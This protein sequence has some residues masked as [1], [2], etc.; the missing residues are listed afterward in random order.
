MLHYAVDVG[1]RRVIL[2]GAGGR[3]KGIIEEL[4]EDVEIVAILDND[5][6]KWNNLLAGIKV[7]NPLD[8]YKMYYDIIFIVP[9]EYYHIHK[10]LIDMGVENEKVFNYTHVELICKETP[11]CCY[12]MSAFSE[13]KNV[14][15]FTHALSSTGAQNV[16]M[17]T[18]YEYQKMGYSVIVIST[19]DG[20]L[21]EE[22][23]NRGVQV[24]IIRDL[25]IHKNLVNELLCRADLVIINTLWL[26][27]V[28]LEICT[29][30]HNV[31]W[32]IH[33]SLNIEFFN[34]TVFS[35]CI[36]R[37]I[38][39]YAVSELVRNDILKAC[40]GRLTCNSIGILRFGIPEYKIE[41]KSHEKMN[42]I[43]LAAMA[44]IKGQDIFI[45]AVKQLPEDIK[46]KAGFFLIGGGRRSDNL[47]EA[48][49]EA[50]VYILDEVPHSEIKAIYEKA[51]V[52]VCPSRKEAM[53][54]TIVEAMMHHKPVIVSD[55]AGIASY[56]ENNKNG[57][58]FES[59]NIKELRDAIL[60]MISNEDTMKL[61]G[62]EEY[63]IYERFFNLNIHRKNIQKLLELPKNKI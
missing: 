23:V 16:L 13:K 52:I 14:I 42:F 49:K 12:G 6:K 57:I 27:Y 21:R 33:E 9:Y 55:A 1:M 59:E 24:K 25:Y 43:V 51:D 22:L 45:E 58:V 44:Y 50:N 47:I 5:K 10:Q 37:G 34:P 7:C 60:W 54:V 63:K 2:F 3:T 26:Y 19:S 8:I 18:V 29:N 40:A 11:V 62:E 15:A 4:K 20:E 30:Y 46:S 41:N 32:W 38:H 53:S 36:D 31:I 28:A 61:M 48:A 17:T 35:M 56:I 39:I